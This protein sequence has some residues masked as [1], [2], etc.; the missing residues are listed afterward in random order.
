MYFCSFPQFVNEEGL[1]VHG[2]IICE[3]KCVYEFM[4]SCIFRN[5]RICMYYVHIH[6]TI[7]GLVKIYSVMG[8]G[9]HVCYVGPG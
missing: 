8:K 6:V 1:S 5:E 3:G 7:K 4:N 9:E 2:Y